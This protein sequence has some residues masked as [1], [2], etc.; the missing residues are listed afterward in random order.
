MFEIREI[1]LEGIDIWDP[2]SRDLAGHMLLK[3]SKFGA[4]CNA[5]LLSAHPDSLLFFFRKAADQI[6]L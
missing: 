3:A 1:D 5:E 4:K 2:A 6:G